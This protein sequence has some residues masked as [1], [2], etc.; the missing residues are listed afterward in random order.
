MNSKKVIVF[1]LDDTLSK[2]KTDI[3]KEMADLVC[4]LLK[5]KYVAVISGA[6]FS[7]FSKQFIKHIQ[8]DFLNKL[9]IL[10]VKGSQFYKYEDGQWVQKYSFEIPKRDREFIKCE[11]YRVLEK[12]G[13]DFDQ[14]LYGDIITDKVA[15]MTLSLQGE[16]A[17]LEVKEKYDQDH[18]KRREIVKLLKPLLPDY[19]IS[20]GGKTS[21]DITPLG[22]DKAYGLNKLSQSIMISLEHFLF[23]GDALF[24]GGNDSSVKRLG[25]DTIAVDGND[26]TVDDTAALIRDILSGKV[27]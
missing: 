21:I 27:G 11:I 5:I 9:Y 6:D 15:G 10:P 23:I 22:I 26:G 12:Y 7:Q 18:S 14:K 2:S 8:C 1:D 19:S 16:N 13:F 24:P 20:I 17:P 3:S 25:I 4:R